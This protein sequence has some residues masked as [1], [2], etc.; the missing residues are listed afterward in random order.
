MKKALSSS[1]EKSRIIDE[2]MEK[3]PLNLEIKNKVNTK[4][5]MKKLAELLSRVVID[6]M[7]K[8]TCTKLPPQTGKFLQCMIVNEEKPIEIRKLTVRMS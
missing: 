3:T 2:M 1:E 6:E 8:K 7:E 5:I 4:N